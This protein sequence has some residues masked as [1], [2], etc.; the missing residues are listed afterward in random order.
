MTIQT[1]ESQSLLVF[2]YWDKQ[3]MEQCAYT[4]F[5]TQIFINILTINQ[6]SL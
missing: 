4:N 5:R 1:F 3:K 2:I 6:W